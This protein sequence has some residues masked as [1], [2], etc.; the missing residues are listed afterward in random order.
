M[1]AER[2]T[3]RTR[4]ARIAVPS[5]SNS[6]PAGTTPIAQILAAVESLLRG[7]QNVPLPRQGID[8]LFDAGVVARCRACELSWPVKHTQFS[9]IAWWSCPSGCQPSDATHA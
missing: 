8:L 2:T 1:R 3:R 6:N 9:S 7:R 4:L 5:E